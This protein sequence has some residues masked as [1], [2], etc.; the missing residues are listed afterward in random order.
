MKNGWVILFSVCLAVMVG[1]VSC[2]SMGRITA[3]SVPRMSI[4]A[5]KA[6]LSDPAVLVLDVR[7]GRSWEKGTTKIKGAVRQD[8]GKDVAVWS[9]GYAKDKTYVL[10]CS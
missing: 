5:L 8:P 10:Y 7:D 9:K 3:P 4:D 2:S 6:R 1:L